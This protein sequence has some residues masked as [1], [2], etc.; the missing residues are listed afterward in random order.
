MNGL[1]FHGWGLL[2]FIHFKEPC[3]KKRSLFDELWVSTNL[4]SNKFDVTGHCEICE[5][6]TC[7][8][9]WHNIKTGVTRCKKCFTPNDLK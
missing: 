2:S 8:P 5:R 4:F 7:R 1:V 3:V 9:I 6:G